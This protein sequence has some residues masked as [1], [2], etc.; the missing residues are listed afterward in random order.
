MSTL[1]R[2]L[3]N[4]SAKPTESQPKNKRGRPEKLLKIDDTPESVARA[5]WGERS[6]KF[7]EKPE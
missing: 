2:K 1:S 3:T 6:T 7:P 4:E 5:L